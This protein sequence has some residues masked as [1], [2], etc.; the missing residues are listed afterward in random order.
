MS[1]QYPERRDIEYFSNWATDKVFQM[2]KKRASVNFKNIADFSRSAAIYLNVFEGAFDYSQNWLRRR[3]SDTYYIL[4]RMQH[5]ETGTEEFEELEN[6][7]I[8]ILKFIVEYFEENGCSGSDEMSIY[9]ST[10][11]WRP[12]SRWLIDNSEEL[13]SLE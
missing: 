1:R 10:K 11:I 7:L 3:I 12:P 6:D 9:D 5:L 4:S 13:D 8:N 2:A